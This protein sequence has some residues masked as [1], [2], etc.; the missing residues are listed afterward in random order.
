MVHE[1]DEEQQIHKV[2]CDAICYRRDSL[3]SLNVNRRCFKKIKS[4]LEM[5]YFGV[6]VSIKAKYGAEKVTL[7]F[8]EVFKMS[9]DEHKK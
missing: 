3:N 2:L 8:D 4:L 5:M 6:C 7:L 1:A 9:V